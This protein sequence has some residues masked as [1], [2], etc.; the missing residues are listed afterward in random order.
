MLATLGETL[1]A[2]FHF[3]HSYLI[4]WIPLFPFYRV[5]YQSSERLNDLSKVTQ[6]TGGRTGIP[7]L[8]DS[9]GSVFM[10]LFYYNQIHIL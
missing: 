7:T 4:K 5:R 3:I 10:A 1:H 2:P 8:S 6:L 9:K